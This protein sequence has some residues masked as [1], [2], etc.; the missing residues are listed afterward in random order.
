MSNCKY[1][2]APENLPSVINATSFIISAHYGRRGRAS[3]S[4]IPGPPLGPPY[5]I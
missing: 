1:L 2:V 3:I 5:I 4:G